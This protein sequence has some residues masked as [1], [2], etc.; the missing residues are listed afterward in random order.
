MKTKPTLT[1]LEAIHIFEN[2]QLRGPVVAEALTAT[3]TMA[4][5]ALYRQAELEYEQIKDNIIYHGKG[6]DADAE[7]DK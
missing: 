5:A 1:T 6:G 4:L 2:C 7:P 3:Y